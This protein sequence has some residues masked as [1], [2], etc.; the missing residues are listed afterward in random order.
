[1]KEVAFTLRRWLYY[2]VI[3]IALMSLSTESRGQLVEDLMSNPDSTILTNL[4]SADNGLPD[5]SALVAG[6]MEETGDAT[7]SLPDDSVIIAG[8]MDQLDSVLAD[9]SGVISGALQTIALIDSLVNDELDSLNAQADGI[10]QFIL[11]EVD[12]IMKE[13]DTISSDPDSVVFAETQ[14]LFDTIGSKVAQAMVVLGQ[15]QEAIAALDTFVR[16]SVDAILLAVQQ[17]IA[18]DTALAADTAA[19]L[20]NTVTDLANA[21]VATADSLTDSLSADVMDIVNNL[22]GAEDVSAL[23]I[24]DEYQII[25]NSELLSN[26]VKGDSV[27]LEV[28]IVNT[29]IDGKVRPFTISDAV[30]PIK[31]GSYNDGRSTPLDLNDITVVSQN[32]NF[33]STFGY[34]GLYYDATN[35]ASGIL[36]VVVDPA[37]DSIKNKT[38]GRHPAFDDLYNALTFTGYYPILDTISLIKFRMP[39]N[40]AGG[41]VGFELLDVPNTT[42]VRSGAPFYSEIYDASK[43]VDGNVTL[44][45]ITIASS[46]A[47]NQFCEGAAV[48]FYS[49]VHQG[50]QWLLNNEALS[51]SAARTITLDTLENGDAITAANSNAIASNAV[52]NTSFGIDTSAAITNTI[53]SPN[54]TEITKS[55]TGN[56]CEGAAILY[57]AVNNGQGNTF[58]WSVLNT[59]TGNP[60]VLN[61]DYSLTGGAT[62]GTLNVTWLKDA[63]YTVRVIYTHSDNALSCIADTNT[64]S[65]VVN[66]DVQLVS[67]TRSIPGNICDGAVVTY[68]A[69]LAAGSAT[70]DST[71]YTWTIAGTLLTANQDYGNFSVTDYNKK[72]ISV[73]WD[74]AATYAITVLAANPVSGTS[75][76]VS[77]TLNVSQV[78]NPDVALTTITQNISGNLCEGQA[79]Q[80]TA[81]LAAGSAVPTATGYAWSVNGS[82]IT[83]N[84][85]DPSGNFSVASFNAKTITLTWLVA[86]SAAGTNYTVGVLATNP[87]TGTNCEISNAVSVIQAVN[88][89][90][91]LTTI[92]PSITANICDGATVTYT[93]NLANGSAVPAVTGYTWTIGT[94][95][96][97]ED[98]DYGDFRVTDFNK[99]TVSVTWDTPATYVVKVKAANPVIGS[100]CNVSNEITGSQ[101][102][103]A[104]VALTDITKSITGNVCEGAAVVYTANLAAGSAVPAATGYTWSV[105][106]VA[107]TAN[108]DQGDFSVANFNQKVMTITWESVT[109]PNGTFNVSVLAANPVTG[110]DC[111]VSNEVSASQIVNA[112]VELAGI[113]P[114]KAGAVC[115]Q[116]VVS[117]TADLAAGSAVP[118]ATGYT[119]VIEG[120]PLA[121][122][123]TTPVYSI[124]GYNTQTLQVTWFQSKVGGYALSVS[125][126]NP[127]TG[128]ECNVSNTVNY[129]QLVN[130]FSALAITSNR[131]QDSIKLGDNISLS[132]TNTIVGGT[133]S[134]VTYAWFNQN[135][136]SDTLSTDSVFTPSPE[137]DATTYVVNVTNGSCTET[138]SKLVH[139][140]YFVQLPLK[141]ILEGPYNIA[142]GQMD[143]NL[144]D[145]L[146]T[147]YDS[148]DTVSL[149]TEDEIN[150]LLNGSTADY[151]RMTSGSV[152]ADAV[153][154][155]EISI[156][157]TAGGANVAA[158]VGMN[159]GPA[160]EKQLAWL[161]KDGS[162]MNYA[163]AER[164]NIRFFDQSL[165]NDTADYFVVIRHRNHV[166]V[167]SKSV[168][169]AY[170]T[171]TAVDLTSLTTLSGIVGNFSKLTATKYAMAAADINNSEIVNTDDRNAV[172]RDS[173]NGIRGYNNGRGEHTDVNLDGIVNAA[174]VNIATRNA[175][176]L[177]QTKVVNP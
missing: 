46:V 1:M 115:E 105:G 84:G 12:P 123:V 104:D 114:N 11:T 65:Q 170:N 17:E 173:D 122:N 20:M 98:K 116:A 63:A 140:A 57:T 155:I 53:I 29:G 86:D 168:S 56:I 136:L 7:D 62:S 102:V 6:A 83:A 15:V 121:S 113:T 68:T 69:D 101:T 171:A 75:C 95:V 176:I 127:V 158:K 41:V 88:A 139:V 128:T 135:D 71:G 9:T 61:T 30:L 51:G 131:A 119:W 26:T 150:M 38:L 79:V 2:F 81:N 58:A 138:A 34:D 143:N 130:G 169:L 44:R 118:S 165:G 133:R 35:R 93:A 141:V 74:T 50:N 24:N 94:T 66:P 120:T 37:D 55:I 111:Q 82:P 91:V 48:T 172:R 70:P 90:V 99:K 13:I 175:A 27:T 87:V 47:T 16:D 97:T 45:P 67:V 151:P 23:F 132:A 36:T 59:A 154:I 162:I 8:A 125:A 76:E 33:N 152:P 159:D 164:N 85:A 100:D 161:L 64:V 77:N 148:E 21:T 28:L 89:D 40:Q 145:M 60:A 107:I 167:V 103:N 112:D 80:Y 49:N 72:T 31:I 134:A 73:T 166:S 160:I 149:P 3:P 42:T 5:D 124:T 10:V 108:G 146:H 22:P 96:L 39:V 18:E 157:R 177:Y 147:L 52:N 19:F 32:E 54:V 163:T 110:T 4:D 137:V 142:T 117:Y 174:D 126:N 144:N 156:R 109:A 129:T 14:F 106:G 92:T 78:V 153:D 43:I 25:L